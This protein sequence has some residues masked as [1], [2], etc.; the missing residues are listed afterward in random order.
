MGVLL[1]LIKNNGRYRTVSRL[2][3]PLFKPLP[4]Q[5]VLYCYIR[6]Y[7]RFQTW[8]LIIH[9]G[10]VYELFCK[11]YEYIKKIEINH[12]TN[13]ESIINLIVFIAVS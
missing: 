8:H 6:L 2:K 5:N 7:R 13:L 9:F 3:N 1:H 12:K 11:P 10:R 4:R